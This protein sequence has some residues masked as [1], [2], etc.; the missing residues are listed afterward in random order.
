M[1]EIRLLGEDER[2]AMSPAYTVVPLASPNDYTVVV[3]SQYP[4]G[5]WWHVINLVQIR[6]GKLY[7][8]DN[9][10]APEL[11]SPLAES[12]AAYRPG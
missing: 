8:L 2:Y 11:P 6:E 4:D 1:P 3:R 12:I 10:F 7:R 9:Y 5:S